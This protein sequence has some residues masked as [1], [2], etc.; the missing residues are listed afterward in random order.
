MKNFGPVSQQGEAGTGPTYRTLCRALVTD[1]E[2]GSVYLTTSEG[3]ILRYSLKTDTIEAIPGED[4]KK[5]YFGTYDP[6]STGHMGYNWRQAF[7]YA[8]E[9]AIYAV[10]GNS[11]YLFRFKPKAPSVDVLERITSEP[12][13]RSGMFDRFYYGYLGFA[14]GPDNRTIYYLTGGPITRDGKRVIARSNFAVGARGEENLHLI[15]YDIPAGKYADRG[16]IFYDDG[17]KPSY[18]NSIAIGKDGS[19]Y[20]L[21]RTA[22]GEGARTDLIQIPR[23]QL[24]AAQ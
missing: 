16:P 10:H 2:D 4:L 23:S 6:T 12:S 8:P 1:A 21:A 7:W 9:G 14:L 20:A 19:V 15:T 22:E 11:G 5:D 18:C 13:R 24:A 3:A 17:A